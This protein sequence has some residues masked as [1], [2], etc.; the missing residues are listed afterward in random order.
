MGRMSQCESDALFPNYIGEGLVFYFGFISDLGRVRA[1]EWRR[2]LLG[3]RQ[4]YRS[5]SV[6]V[7]SAAQIE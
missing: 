7:S 4:S 6:G 3:R 2:S 5:S 1:S